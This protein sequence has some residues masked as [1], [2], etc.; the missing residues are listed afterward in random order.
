MDRGDLVAGLTHDGLMPAADVRRAIE[1]PSPSGARLRWARAKQAMRERLTSGG[2][3]VVAGTERLRPGPPVVSCPICGWRGFRYRPQTESGQIFWNVICPACGALPRHRLF[4]LA[5]EARRSA[6]AGTCLYMAPEPWL[7]PILTRGMKRVIRMD[8]EASGVDVWAN[9]EALP[10]PDESVDIVIANDVLEHVEHDDRALA[11]LRRILTL[12]GMAFIHVPV[13]SD[14]TVEFGY[15]NPF[16]HGHRRSY[17]PDV[18]DRFFAAGLELSMFA[19]A[20]LETSKQ[21]EAGLVAYD[22]VLIAQVPSAQ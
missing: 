19:S 17:G 14:E 4:I 22:A 13:T 20:I 1:A 11:E 2:R 12:D 5:W 10:L 18:V 7:E 6:R 9:A 3:K 8:L 21:R 15:A 16:A